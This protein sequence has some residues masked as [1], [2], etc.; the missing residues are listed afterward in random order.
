MNSESPNQKEIFRNSLLEAIQ[1]VVEVIDKSTP[2][3]DEDKDQI[4]TNVFLDLLFQELRSL[5]IDGR[6]LFSEI[7]EEQG[8]FL[9]YT[10]AD[11]KLLEMTPE[12]TA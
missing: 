8:S 5:D 2:L 3:S 6:I 10:D 1:Q 11:I 4:R 7:L 12:G 9:K